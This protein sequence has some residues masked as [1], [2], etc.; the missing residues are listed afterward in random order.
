MCT[1]ARI[2]AVSLAFLSLAFSC[3]E[4]GSYV[5]DTTESDRIVSVLNGW[6]SQA[7]FTRAE[8]AEYSNFTNAIKGSCYEDVEPDGVIDSVLLA[9]ELESGQSI[10][11]LISFHG[12]VENRRTKTL[13]SLGAALA[14]EFGSGSVRREE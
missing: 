10:R 6:A 14:Y 2:A 3:T 4:L 1:R 11:V 7:G 8:C 12:T 13:A 9:E 5:V